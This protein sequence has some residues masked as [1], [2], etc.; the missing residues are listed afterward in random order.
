[1]AT[2]VLNASCAMPTTRK[3]GRPSENGACPLLP[4]H[5][6]TAAPAARLHYSK[7]GGVW[8]PLRARV[9]TATLRKLDFGSRRRKQGAG[10]RSRIGMMGRPGG[11]RAPRRRCRPHLA[12]HRT[13]GAATVVPRGC[14]SRKTTAEAAALSFC[15]GVLCDP[16]QCGD[17]RLYSDLAPRAHSTLQRRPNLWLR[18]AAPHD[19]NLKTAKRL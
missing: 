15:R 18:N 17:L 16:L 9:C 13:V 6:L 14:E 5:I 4:H 7:F 3:A 19:Q 11:S 1:M 10:R 8:R 12:I 2:S